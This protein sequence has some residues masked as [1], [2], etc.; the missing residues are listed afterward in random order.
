MN[1][2]QF[3][4]GRTGIPNWPPLGTPVARHGTR[5]REQ[6][7]EF[8]LRELERRWSRVPAG[9]GRSRLWTPVPD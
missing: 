1:E 3:S 9:G 6:I 5:R 4:S 2:L 8:K 7:I